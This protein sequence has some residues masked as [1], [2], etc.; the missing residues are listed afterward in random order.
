MYRKQDSGIPEIFG[1]GVLNP[2]TQARIQVPLTKIPE[3][4]SWNPKSAAL[5]PKSKTAFDSVTWGEKCFQ[6]WSLSSSVFE[7]RS[8]QKPEELKKNLKPSL[9]FFFWDL[10]SEIFL[11]SDLTTFFLFLSTSFPGSNQERTL[12]KRLCF[13]TFSSMLVIRYF[14]SNS[15]HER[16]NSL[17]QLLANSTQYCRRPRATYGYTESIS[18]YSTVS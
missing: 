7:H 18:E 16:N 15:Y 12:G 3:S 11:L 13:V 17:F 6:W 10:R 2:N 5:N 4:S 9:I 1:C 8:G 14:C